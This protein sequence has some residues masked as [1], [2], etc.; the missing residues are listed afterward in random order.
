M[1]TLWK[2]ASK[3]EF[4]QMKESGRLSIA[5]LMTLLRE[6]S[7]DGFNV[8]GAMAELVALMNYVT[9]SQCR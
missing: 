6:L 5:H 9:S 1:I 7:D 8:D 3:K 2:P 4:I